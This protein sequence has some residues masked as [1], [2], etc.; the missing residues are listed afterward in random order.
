MSIVL[1]VSPTLLG[2]V[3]AISALI[4][5]LGLMGLVLLTYYLRMV[6]HHRVQVALGGISL[7]MGIL[8]ALL[9]YLI[10]TEFLPITLSPASFYVLIIF[11]VISILAGVL[12]IATRTPKI[13]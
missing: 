1:L 11:S 5:G 9:T 3:N 4:S 10:E 6:G 2:D 7:T 8:T 12:N 13:F